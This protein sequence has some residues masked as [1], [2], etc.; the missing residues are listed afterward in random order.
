MGDEAD[1]DLSVPCVPA[2]AVAIY[3]YI[4]F[5]LFG[6]LRE[7]NAKGGL[8]PR[9]REKKPVNQQRAK[10]GLVEEEVGQIVTGIQGRL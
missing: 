3:I 4:Y 7:W 2:V 9:G 8:H 10:R 5:F 6:P 1:Y